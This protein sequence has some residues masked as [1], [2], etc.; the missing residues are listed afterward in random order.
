[1]YL[2]MYIYVYQFRMSG[3][4]FKK[5]ITK[6]VDTELAVGEMTCV[7]RCVGKYMMAQQKVGDVLNEFEKQMKAKDAAMAQQQQKFQ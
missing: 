4:C 2:S 1:M 3:T 5:C 7:D 6:Y